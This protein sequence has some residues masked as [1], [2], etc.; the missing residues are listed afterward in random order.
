MDYIIALDDFMINDKICIQLNYDIDFYNTSTEIIKDNIILSLNTIIQRYDVKQDGFI[1]LLDISKVNNKDL[2]V[3]KIKTLLKVVS[4]KFPDMLHKCIVYNYSKTVKML[5]NLIKNF[6]DK[7]TAKK[8]VIDESIS[9]VINSV[10][11]DPT[12]IDK[13]TSNNS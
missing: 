1:F 3:A 11:K 4:D 8:I 7:P 12:L 5:F 10:T 9:M 2:E 6:L 13:I